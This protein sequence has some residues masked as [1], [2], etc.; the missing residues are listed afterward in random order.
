MEIG[1]LGKLSEPI[2]WSKA[3]SAELSKI[4][5]TESDK[6]IINYIIDP[7]SRGPSSLYIWLVQVAFDGMLP[8]TLNICLFLIFILNAVAMVCVLFLKPAPRV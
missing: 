2:E 6:Y 1:P 5:E 8:L 7:T 4:D 3:R